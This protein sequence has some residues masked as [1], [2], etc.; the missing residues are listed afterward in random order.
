MKFDYNKAE[1]FSATLRDQG[2]LSA[3]NEINR[4]AGQYFGDES[5][6]EAV[7]DTHCSKRGIDLS[8][9]LS[10]LTNDLIHVMDLPQHDASFD[11]TARENMI[12]WAMK[13]T[14]LD[15]AMN[16]SAVTISE[17]SDLDTVKRGTFTVQH[18]EDLRKLGFSKLS[19]IASAYILRD[20]K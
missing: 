10:S 18:T 15:A 4:A 17:L 5:K 3:F 2:L 8:K 13:E 12:R 16:S 20:L 1:A 11:K 6:R 7:L 9:E 14:F 19:A